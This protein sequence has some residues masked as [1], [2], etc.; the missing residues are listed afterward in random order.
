[1]NRSNSIVNEIKAKKRLHYS[2]K[3]IQS[4]TYRNHLTWLGNPMTASAVPAFAYSNQES[5]ELVISNYFLTSIITFPKLE[6]VKREPK[7][8]K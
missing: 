8:S 2:N 3:N 5:M 1:M 7:L 6:L 4:F